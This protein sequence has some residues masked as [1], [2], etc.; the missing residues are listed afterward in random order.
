M[1]IYF[2]E[3]KKIFHLQAADTSYVLQI[4]RDGY[5]KH[6]YWGRKIRNYHG[7]NIVPGMDRS[8]AP[9]PDTWDRTFSLDALPQEYP[10]Y[11]NSDFRTPAYQIQLANGST[12]TDLRYKSH[13]IYAGKQPLQGLPAVYTEQPEEADTLE[14]ILEDKLIGLEVVLSYTAFRSYDVIT[15]NARLINHGSQEL[16]IL[17]A[18][19]A[20]VDFDG[21]DYDVLYLPGAHC[22]ERVAERQPVGHYRQVVESRRG[23]S[24]HQEN[25][26]LALL[27]KNADEQQGE[28]YAMNLVYSGNFLAQVEAD[29]FDVTRM[30]IG[31]NPFDFSWRLGQDESF[32]TPEAV[33]VYSD[34]GLGKMSRTLHR[35]YR[36]RLCRGKYRDAERPVLVN[37]WEATYFNFNEK[38]LFS[39]ADDARDLGIELMVLD[40]GWFGKRDDDNSSLG[41]WFVDQRKLPNG[42]A[43]V[44]DYVNQQGMKFGLWFEPE[45]ISVESELYKAHPDWCLHVPERA[46]SG[47]RNQLILDLSRP[48]V[49][50]YIIRVVSDV[51]KSASISYVKWDMNRH[52]TEIGSA[53]LPALQ[54][55]ETAHRYML[56]LYR[57]LEEITAAFPDILFESC[58]GGGGRF[59]PGMLYYMP[60][61]W[62]S[63]DT[64][65]ME[66]LK[67]QYGTSLAY[68]ASTMGS[69]VSA[70]PNHQLGRI[71]PI[72]T[73]GAVAMAG[74][75][76]Y[77]LDL[78]KLSAEDKNKIRQQ[79][80]QYKELRHLLQ[81]GDLYRLKS[82]LA[83]NET[84]WMVVSADQKEAY[85]TYVRVLAEA[86]PANCWLH[87]AGLA[88][89]QDYKV[90]V[91]A[92][93]EMGET[94]QDIPVSWRI[95]TE[96][97]VAGGDELM[98]TGLYVPILMGDY[99][100]LCWHLR[101]VE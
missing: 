40:D 60:Q 90:S 3:K 4:V 22:R 56:G 57:V 79:V 71:T 35:L 67:I 44:A 53:V 13:R 51:L 10:A 9:N 41:D 81:F 76:G 83:G 33:L 20:N 73:R 66:R 65:A 36:T 39:L 91:V 6:S 42:L 63:D 26:F 37:N 54:Q 78:T 15:R 47:G 14:I 32:Q 8:F 87:L 97:S 58:S 48:E 27:S 100:S 45:M 31:I 69:H 52:M 17:Q 25:P 68:P 94:A 88:E 43:A 55:R 11:G 80:A 16:K 92:M 61:T 85:V 49:C 82:P 24:S 29:Q 2:D 21:A 93:Q 59:D 12:I 62:T 19:S 50:D 5:L 96:T 101:A 64:D 98:H 70:V 28:V 30:S 46:R 77:E 86:N 18:L 23:A 74:S 75:F 84:A 95:K 1:S 38:K 7:S 34:R 89:A 99:R 72:E